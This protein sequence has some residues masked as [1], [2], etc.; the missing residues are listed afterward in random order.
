MKRLTAEDIKNINEIYKRVGSYAETAR[1]TGFAPT[2]VK[3]YVDPD[4]VVEPFKGKKF[5]G[6]LQEFDSTP[7]MTRD[8]SKLCELSEAEKEEL[9]SLWEELR[10]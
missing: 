8:W 9:E 5:E 6:E 1:Q 4:Y 2:T 10:V 3:K 7:F